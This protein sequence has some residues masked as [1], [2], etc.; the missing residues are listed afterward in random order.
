MGIPDPAYQTEVAKDVVYQQVLAAEN[1]GAEHKTMAKLLKRDRKTVGMAKETMMNLVAH[2]QSI[3]SAL[4]K[5]PGNRSKTLED[6]EK[7]WGQALYNWF[8]N[9]D[10]ALGSDK[11]FCYLGTVVKQYKN[12]QMLVAL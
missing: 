2:I 9:I 11:F 12:S 8:S 5:S 7:Y 4:R 1:L 6:I 3:V 10:K